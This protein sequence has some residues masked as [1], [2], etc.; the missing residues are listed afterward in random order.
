MTDESLNLDIA[1]IKFIDQRRKRKSYRRI[2][3]RPPDQVNVKI[4]VKSYEETRQVAYAIGRRHSPFYEEYESILEEF[5]L[6]KIELE[7]TQLI[8]E[9]ARKDKNDLKERLDSL[10]S[11]LAITTNNDCPVILKGGS[12]E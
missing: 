7:K 6:I 2:G 11:K 12:N 9:D 4:T 1:N 5:A 3:S 10:K 8:L